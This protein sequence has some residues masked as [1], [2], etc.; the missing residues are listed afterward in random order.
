MKTIESVSPV[1]T[2]DEL[3]KKEQIMLISEN[4]EIRDALNL[5]LRGYPSLKYDETGSH[6]DVL[7]VAN[8]GNDYD[9][10]VAN[11]IVSELQKRTGRHF[12]SKV[13]VTGHSDPN[14]EKKW[15]AFYIR[16]DR[17]SQ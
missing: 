10:L 4:Q 2:C 1:V 15:T 17:K 14:Y 7:R 13:G 11:E 6:G 5:I 9:M 12:R 3:F 8:T 16:P